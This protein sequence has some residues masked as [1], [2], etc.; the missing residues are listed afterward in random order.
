MQQLT[1][2]AM[3]HGQAALG[4]CSMAGCMEATHLG[5]PQIQTCIS[6]SHT[7]TAAAQATSQSRLVHDMGNY[8]RSSRGWH[9]ALF[10]MGSRLCEPT[11]V[12]NKTLHNSSYKPYVV[13]ST[14]C[15]PTCDDPSYV[16]HKPTVARGWYFATGMLKLTYRSA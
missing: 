4:Q 15:M 9:F 5:L 13:L 14:C 16:E 6:A 12:N 3:P 10:P 11:F 7:E 8:P 1:V 2:L